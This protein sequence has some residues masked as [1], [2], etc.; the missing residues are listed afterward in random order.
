MDKKAKGKVP[1]AVKRAEKEN[2]S[3][4]E[5]APAMEKPKKKRS[6]P[7]TI[8][9]TDLLLNLIVGS[10]LNTMVTNK[11]TPYGRLKNWQDVHRAFN[12]SAEVTVC[13]F[14]SFFSFFFIFSFIIP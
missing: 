14:L 7:F 1:K 8:H 10:D 9:E 12:A 5:K 3:E 13:F 6:A 2:V 11:L 4:M